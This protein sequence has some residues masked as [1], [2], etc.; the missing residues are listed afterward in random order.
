MTR[1]TSK[2]VQVGLTDTDPPDEPC[3]CNRCF[4]DRDMLGQ[5]CLKHTVIQIA[6]S[7]TNML[8]QDIR[9]AVDNKLAAAV[10]FRKGIHTKTV[11]ASL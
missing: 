6:P 8:S 7:G 9:R 10:L 2:T 1:Y 3:S 4:H 11:P 5:L